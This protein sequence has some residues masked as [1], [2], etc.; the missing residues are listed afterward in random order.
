MAKREHTH[1]YLINIFDQHVFMKLYYFLNKKKL[2]YN[3]E[4]NLIDDF[5]SSFFM[6]HAINK[7]IY[8][9]RY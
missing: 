6:Y 9:T 7:C 3:L 2:F 5:L 8:I 1:N 4:L